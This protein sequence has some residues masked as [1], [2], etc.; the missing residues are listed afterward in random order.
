MLRPRWLAL[1]VLAV[2]LVVAMVLL[3]RW[4]LIV[5]D[6]KHFNIENFG[7]A[8]QWWAFSVFTIV[9]WARIMRDTARRASGQSPR[10]ESPGEPP[11][12]YRRYV[13]PTVPAAPTD[14]QHAAY[15]DYLARL[16]AEDAKGEP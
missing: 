16:A 10:S 15:N 14:P 7:Y 11:V 2:A 8:L 1:H 4:Q 6:E 13:P 5:S 3:G 12:V 9:M